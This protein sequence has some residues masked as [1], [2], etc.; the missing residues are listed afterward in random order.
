MPFLQD[1]SRV[2]KFSITMVTPPYIVVCPIHVLR[3]YSSFIFI[4]LSLSILLILMDKENG[5]APLAV[6]L[7]V[8]TATG[9]IYK[10][11]AMLWLSNSKLTHK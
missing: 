10:T 1:S 3:F 4:Y 8:A 6:L 2:G 7:T 9:N 11:S 5:C